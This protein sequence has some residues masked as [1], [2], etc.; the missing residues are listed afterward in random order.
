MQILNIA[1]L[2]L[3]TSVPVSLLSGLHLARVDRRRKPLES[4]R[5]S[6]PV[7]AVATSVATSARGNTREPTSSP[8]SMRQPAEV[9]TPTAQRSASGSWAMMMSASASAA[10][11]KARSMA[12]GSSGFGTSTV[13]TLSLIHL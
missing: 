13:G 6:A 12:P 5:A 8:V 3:L 1:G 9:G 10:V 7:H 4:R 2:V 11:A